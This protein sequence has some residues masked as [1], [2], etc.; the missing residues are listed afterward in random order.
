VSQQAV[1]ETRDLVM[2]FPAQSG[3]KNIFRRLPGKAVL[4]NVSLSVQKGEIF[5]LLG[6][7]GAGKTTLVKVLSTLAIPTSG[8][9]YVA[10]INVVKDSLGVRRRLG[11]V[12]G[13]ERTFFWR[14]SAFDN[15]YFYASLLGLDPKPA[16]KV[17][18]EL[19]ELV[20]LDHAAQIRMHHYSSGMRQRASIARGLLNDPEVLIMDEPTRTLD[21]IASRE[22]RQLIKER[23]VNDRRTVLLATNIMA[24]AEFLCDRVAF[25]NHGTIQMVG[26][27]DALRDIL[28]AD[29]VHQIVVGGLPFEAFEPLQHLPGV[30]DF[31]IIPE[32][33]NDYRLEVNV[34]V[35]EPAIPLI[36]RR[37]VEMGGDVWSC[38]RRPLTVEEMFAIVVARSNQE[39][40][41]EAV[42][43]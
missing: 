9:A 29:Q 23:V 22:L 2:Q 43:A 26:E 35:G 19:L 25:I 8:E 17:V 14:L 15:L 39:R 28:Q 21:P 24:E 38:G 10:G 32:G 37:I 20:G 12:Y 27:I 36:I 16:R 40:E 1:I 41:K 4:D 11:V 34:K 3:W 13:D 33:E 42:E 5:G 6:P 18:D 31:K 30:D 7:N